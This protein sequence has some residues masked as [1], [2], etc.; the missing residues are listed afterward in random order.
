MLNN[1]LIVDIN[2]IYLSLWYCLIKIYGL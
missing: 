2:K 1:V